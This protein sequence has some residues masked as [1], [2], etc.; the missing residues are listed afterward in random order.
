M[1]DAILLEVIN[2]KSIKKELPLQRKSWSYNPPFSGG[3][4]PQKTQTWQ[5]VKK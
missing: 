3:T 5:R 4:A 2:V 1:L